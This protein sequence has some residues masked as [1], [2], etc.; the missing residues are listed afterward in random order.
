MTSFFWNVR[1][2]NQSTKHAVVRE[3]LK[4]IEA[5][6]GCLIETRVKERKVSRI[7]MESFRD[8][9]VITNYEHNPLGRIW[10]IWKSKM[11]LTPVFKSSHIITC[12]VM[13]DGCK[14]EFFCSFVYA[15]NTTEERRSLWEDIRN[16]S[17]S[18]LFKKKAWVLMGD[19][20]EILE[21]N[22]H[23]K[24][25]APA[26]IPNGMRDFQAVVEHCSLIDMSYQGPLHT[27]CNKREEGLICKKLDRVLIN[28]EWIQQFSRVYS[29]FEAGGCS[30][31]SLFH[32]AVHSFNSF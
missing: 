2:F 5:Q 6:F 19:F 26:S 8:W 21:S 15:L 7:L 11:R 12:S 20:N 28:E 25:G 3:W 30:D 13:M 23:T 16:H 17:D 31:R 9:D 14:E 1:G 29:V 32:N 22:E 10:V 4:G 24:F 18:G 27:W